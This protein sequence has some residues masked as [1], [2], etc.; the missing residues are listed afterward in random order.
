MRTFTSGMEYREI[1]R[2]FL[3]NGD[4][5]SSETGS[6]RIRQGYLNTDPERT[7]RVRIKDDRGFLTVK[8]LTRGAERFEWEREIPSDEAEKLLALCEGDIIDKVRH[9][10]PFKGHLWEVDEFSSGLVIAEI[11]LASA[12]EQFEIPSWAGDEVTGD[13][14]FYNSNIAKS[15]NL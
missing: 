10:V 6:V 12:D 4:F 3:V 13:P 9:L 14:R 5:K 1:E 2:K 8:G 11:E 7:V 15:A